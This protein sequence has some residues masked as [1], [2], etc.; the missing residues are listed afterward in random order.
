[1]VQK[2]LMPNG[3]YST[4]GI[5]ASIVRPPGANN[6]QDIA[7]QF[8]CLQPGFE[9]N[10]NGNNTYLAQI[11]TGG[12]GT[13]INGLQTIDYQYHIRGALR[14]INLDGSQNPTPNTSEGDL[15]SYK[16][17][18]E[19]AGYFDGNIGKQTW[20]NGV[21]QRSYQYNYDNASR[22]KSAIYSGVN[23]EDYSIP[24]MN[25]DKNGNILNLQELFVQR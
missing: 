21:A 24:N 8:I 4:G 14:G 13:S 12:G 23:G 15:F 22:L 1:M 19:T 10:A 25:Y 7:S 17:D 9:T 11:G 2:K 5:P 18:Y 6:T 3:T 16:L 20:H